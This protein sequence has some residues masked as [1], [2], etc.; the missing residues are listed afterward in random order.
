MVMAL[1]L[2]SYCLLF[3]PLKGYV[4]GSCIVVKYFVLAYFLSCV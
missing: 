1:L 2:F 4:L 3:L